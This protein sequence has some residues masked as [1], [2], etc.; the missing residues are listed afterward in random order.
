M[1]GETTVHG[2]GVM[3]VPVPR[4]RVQNGERVLS[5]PQAYASAIRRA[6][7][8]SDP[9][10]SRYIATLVFASAAFFTERLAA[11]IANAGAGLKCIILDAEAISD[12]D[13]TAAEALE[14]LDGD[15]ER[16]GVDL[17]IARANG[18]LRDLLT[19]TG[20]MKRLGAEHIYPSVR[21]AVV[22]YQ[23]QFGAAS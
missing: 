13:S 11:L 14:T 8:E 20:L 6:K 7:I 19:A 5:G 2:Y 4:N 23:A 22:A 21:A 15:L 16:L 9:K 10:N 3:P 17:W 1:I 18:P 12:F